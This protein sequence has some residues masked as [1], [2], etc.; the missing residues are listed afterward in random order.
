ME[1]PKD[2]DIQKAIEYSYLLDSAY[3]GFWGNEDSVKE[4]LDPD[5]V[6]H[7][8]VYS[9]ENKAREFGLIL[10]KRKQAIFVFRGTIPIHEWIQ[11]FQTSLVAWQTPLEQF[12]EAKVSQGFYHIYEN[13]RDE[14]LHHCNELEMDQL[15]L[16]GHSLGGV[17]SYYFALD[18]QIKYPEMPL[19]VYSFASPHPGNKHFRNAFESFRIPTFS[20]I[21]RDDPVT[22][23]PRADKYFPVGKKII[24]EETALINLQLHF[25]E[26]YRD[27]LKD[28]LHS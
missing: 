10:T 5:L 17:I 1:L 2:F 22:K 3:E 8:F 7:D 25:V 16:V 28:L 14:L 11:N 23:Y 26:K 6:L 24:L 18:H 4:N 13:L 27:A 15:T 20:I 19:E 21:N 12:P 9:D